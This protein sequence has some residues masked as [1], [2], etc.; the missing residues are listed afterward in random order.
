MSD[1]PQT[2]LVIDDHPLLRKGVSQLVAMEPEMRLVGEAAD[3]SEG[4]KLA[5][6][7]EP[8][9]ILLDLQ[10]KGMNGLETLKAIKALDTDSR[11]IMFTV[12]DS[13]DDILAALQ[14]GADGY[15]LN[16]ME[17]EE[18]LANLRMAARGRLVLSGPVTELLARSLRN[19]SSSGALP[20]ADLTD[21]EH[22]I[23]LHIAEGRSNKLIARALDIT[24]GTVKVHVKHLLKKLN[25]RS[26]VEAA[27]WAVKSGIAQRHG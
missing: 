8:D 27:V 22:E 12:S 17:P 19:E 9:L 16:D 26:R 3:G 5:R 24:E 11:V 25:L 14:A 6:Q 23:L 13:E 4:L 18:M 21:R 10:M 20:A 1:A 15:L 7:L 2:L